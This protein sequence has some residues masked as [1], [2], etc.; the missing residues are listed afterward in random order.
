MENDHLLSMI[1]NGPS[2]CSPLW[3]EELSISQPQQG[4]SEEGLKL[5]ASSMY[6]KDSF[7]YV[8]PQPTVWNKWDQIQSIDCQVITNMYIVYMSCI[9]SS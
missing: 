7:Q 8:Q 1:N 3:E 5:I 4:D 6:N 2:Y 9:L